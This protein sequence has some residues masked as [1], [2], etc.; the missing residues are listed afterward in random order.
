MKGPIDRGSP[1]QKSPDPMPSAARRKAMMLVF[2]ATSVVIGA[3]SMLPSCDGPPE[4]T[5][6]ADRV[7]ALGVAEDAGPNRACTTCLQTKNAP[8]SC[9]DAVGACDD[10]PTKECVPSFRAAHLCV[11]HGGPSEE[12]RCKGL[13][14]NEK[15][16]TLYSCM[17]TN[18]GPECGVPSCDLDPAV[19]LFANPV[20]DDCMGG[21]C[22]EKINACYRDRRCKLIV[23][24]ITKHC[25]R[26]LGPSMTLLG[27]AGS[28]AIES[29][30]S[31]VCS[32]TDVPGGEGSNAC[33]QRCL[34]DF[35]PT[36]DAGTTDDRN[37]RCLAFG[38][39][40]CGAE[41]SCGPK[42]MRPDGG[43]YSGDEE[44]PEDNPEGDATAPGGD[45][46]GSGISDASTD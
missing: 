8:K 15:A 35:A 42:C 20:C 4:K 44:W 41:A 46:G 2:V 6:F 29:I 32:G 21:S 11:V 37:A 33:L 7:N 5:C 3:V 25:P 26:T 23:E 12:S 27:N 28:E 36:G 9:C 19:I 45:A 13:L 30:R 1:V 17:R 34:D 39:F 43:A 22:C 40:A 38:V 31:G 18:C 16:Q 24:C 10:D 14:T